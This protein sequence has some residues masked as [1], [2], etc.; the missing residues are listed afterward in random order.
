MLH[1][2]GSG[3][4]TVLIKSP[5]TDIFILPLCSKLISPETPLCMNTGVGDRSRIILLHT[6]SRETSSEFSCALPGF[7]AF[8]G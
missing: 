4:Q 1:A 5:D 8:T 6:I 7:H 2:A 3:S